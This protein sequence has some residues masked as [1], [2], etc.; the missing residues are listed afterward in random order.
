MSSADLTQARDVERGGFA[1]RERGDGPLVILLH[2]LGGSRV[3]WEPQL[4]GLGDRWHVAA[5]DMPGYGAAPPLP[6]ERLTFRALADAAAEWIDALATANGHDDGRA[7]VVGISMGGMIAQY[8]AAWHPN[9]VRSLTLMST[10]PRFGLNGTLPDVWRAARLAPLDR[11]EAPADFA[12]RVLA[13]LGGAHIGPEA[14]AGQVAAMSRISA[15]ALRRSIDCLVT[16]DA[17]ALLPTVTAPVLV[18]GGEFDSETPPEYS[19][20]IAEL[21]PKARTVIVPHAGHLLNVEAPAQVNRL[22][23]DHLAACE[24]DE[25]TSGR[26]PSM[27]TR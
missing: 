16:H 1:W 5:W 23:A 7:H 22:I 26:L 27:E 3:S 18:L 17:R 13:G 25:A 12:E 24:R 21:L 2:G 15:V 8:L 20:A 11:G 14:F 19:H 6:A 10:S 9:S 4:V